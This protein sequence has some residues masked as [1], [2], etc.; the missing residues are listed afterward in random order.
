MVDVHIVL[1]ER[2]R[3]EIDR[4]TPEDQEARQRIQELLGFFEQMTTVYDEF[5][6]LK[7]GR[8]SMRIVI[9]GG[10]GQVGQVLAR[11]FVAKGDSVTVLSRRPQ[12][13]P[14]RV[15]LWDGVS[16]G[17]WVLNWSTA[18]FVLI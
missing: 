7:E 6:G 15:A 11:H 18:T 12:G 8:R 9:A 16:R 2:T 13:V 14:W 10:S 3:P 4:N 1:E 5:C 17:E